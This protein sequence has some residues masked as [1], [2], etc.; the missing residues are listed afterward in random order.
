MNDNDAVYKLSNFKKSDDSQYHISNFKKKGNKSEE[1]LKSIRMN[2]PF[3]SKLAEKLQGNEL[4]NQAGNLAGHFNQ[5]VEGTGLPSLARGFIGTGISAGRGLA[6]LIPG[7]NI[8]EQNYHELNVNPYLG[9]AAETV[10]SL[11]MGLP[12]LKGY[13]GVKAGL[14]HIPYAKNIPNAI[15]SILA[16]AGTGA[17]ISPEHRALGGVLGGTAEAIPAA[18]NTIKS[19]KPNAFEAIQKGY[20]AKLKHAAGMIENVGKKAEKEG[21]TKI[22]LRPNLINDIKEYG[23]KKKSFVALIDKLK[24]GDYQSLRKVQTE[25]FK[26]A[27]KAKSSDFLSEQDVGDKLHDLRDEIN[28]S[29]YEHFNK[30]G[31]TDL[32]EQLRKGMARYKN[33]IDTYHSTPQIAKLVGENRLVPSTSTILKQNSVKMNEL[34]KHHPEIDKQLNYEKNLRKAAYAA[35]AAASLGGLKE[36]K[37]LLSD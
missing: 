12:I 25:L 9:Q 23:P 29:I 35:G 24:S 15:K 14:E 1:E 7:V 26:R 36:A 8:P 32:A 30:S 19:M 3:L 20:D 11:G 31:H 2:H 5:A 21:I 33:L 27:E 16:G 18:I 22:N 34:K 13:Q 17:A 10:G 6:N 4:L 28:Q 37:H